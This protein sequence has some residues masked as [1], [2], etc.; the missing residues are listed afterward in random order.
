MERKREVGAA[1]WGFRELPLEEQLRICKNLGFESLELGIANAPMD[2]P[3][4]AGEKEIQKVVQAYRDYGIK[5]WCGATG[6]D[7]TVD[8]PQIPLEIEKVKKVICICEKANIK[9]LRIFAGFTPVKEVTGVRW[10]RMIEAINEAADFAGV[11]QVVLAIE[12]HGGVKGY[13][14]GVEHFPSVSTDAESLIRLME[15]IRETVVFVFDP[16]N[17]VAVGWKDPLIP[18]GLL[19]KRIGYMHLKNFV[20]LPS[21]RLEPAA[22]GD[23]IADW[24]L[25][26]TGSGS[27]DGPYMI[28][29]EKTES[30]EEGNRSSLKALERW[31]KDYE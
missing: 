9:Y 16:A 6:N 15:E 23:G 5:L 13:E 31:E 29:Y 4:D 14:E 27:Y 26:F 25:F 1:A 12:T 30:I 19:E 18:Y 20:R 22:L 17:L 10:E 21:G 24:P 8:V 2:L 3:A 7:F 28:E 11:H